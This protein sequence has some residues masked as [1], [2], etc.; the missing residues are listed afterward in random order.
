MKV[1]APVASPPSPLPT[2]LKGDLQLASSKARLAFEQ[3][4]GAKPGFEQRTQAGAGRDGRSGAPARQA[5]PSAPGA[6]SGLAP[7][8]ADAN[9]NVPSAPGDTPYAPG[10]LI[11][12]Q[13]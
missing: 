3:A 8:P 10:A 7:A 4:L 11:N 13:A 9:A 12:I 1:H 5:V 6:A 2:A